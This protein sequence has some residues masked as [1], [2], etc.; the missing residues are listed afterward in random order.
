MRGG[1]QESE[2]PACQPLSMA[3]SK[4]VLRIEVLEYRETER[5]L[6]SRQARPQIHLTGLA[7]KTIPQRNEV[8]RTEQNSLETLFSYT[9]IIYRNYVLHKRE[10]RLEANGLRFTAGGCYAWQFYDALRAELGGDFGKINRNLS[11][12]AA[13]R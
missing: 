6:L 1:G 10:E 8:G 3:L 4:I 13:D 5:H 2:R 7:R 9:T 11:A 12:Y